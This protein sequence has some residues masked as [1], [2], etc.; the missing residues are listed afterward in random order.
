MAIA[1]PLGTTAQILSAAATGAGQAYAVPAK[2]YTWQTIVTGT[3]TTIAINLEGSMDGVNFAQIDT[4]ALAGGELRS[5]AN[6]PVAFIRAN[7]ATLTGGTA[8]TVTVIL[9]AY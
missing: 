8:P 1:F 2:A 3:P 7:L 4:S 6:K 5:V 9:G